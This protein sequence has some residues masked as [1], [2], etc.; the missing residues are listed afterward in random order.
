MTD[1]DSRGDR[2][3]PLL[4][5]A[6]EVFARYGYRR[7]SMEDLAEAVGLSRAGLYKRFSSK[8]ALFRAVVSRLHEETLARVDEATGSSTS[9]AS[10]L[11]RVTAAFEAR[12]AYLVERASGSPHG[13]EIMEE[14]SRLCG[15]LVSDAS[16]R[17][18]AKI[19]ALLRE[20][21]ARGEID[22]A[23]AD[24]DPRGAAELMVAAVGGLKPVA[25]GPK[26]FHK[27]MRRLIALLLAGMA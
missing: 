2:D 27:S 26:Q 16:K 7:V 1:R 3:G 8:E 21:H 9:G 24:L 18:R 22:L 5:A 20:G 23:G 14:T 17:F 25:A 15:D 12:V 11:D 6:E 4:A 13:A 10:T 19:A